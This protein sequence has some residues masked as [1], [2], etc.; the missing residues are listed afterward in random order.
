MLSLIRPRLFCAA[1]EPLQA[2][3]KIA[4]TFSGRSTTQSNPRVLAPVVT[5]KV[6]RDGNSIDFT[7]LG[8][9]AASK[10]IH[11]IAIANAKNVEENRAFFKPAIAHGL[12]MDDGTNHKKVLTPFKISLFPQTSPRSFLE[13][14]HMVRRTKISAMEDHEE[15]AKN[16]HLSYMRKTPLVLE[17][18]GERAMGVITHSLALFNDRVKAHDMSAY[19]NIITGKGPDGSDIVKMEFQLVE[20]PKSN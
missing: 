11:A 15:L 8:R 18:M 7:C 9:A 13:S 6:L 17:C 16:I 14:A 19:V 2:A 12:K 10:L 4:E 1:A 3:S 5:Q 20:Q